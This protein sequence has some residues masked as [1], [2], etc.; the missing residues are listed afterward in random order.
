MSRMVLVL[1]VC[2]CFGALVVCGIRAMWCLLGMIDTLKKRVDKLEEC[3]AV[4]GVA[5][6]G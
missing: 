5:F 3:E 2:G 1:C 6:Y 4:G